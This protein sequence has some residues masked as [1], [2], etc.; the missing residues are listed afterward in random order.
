MRF[1]LI[2]LFYV[3][4]LLAVITGIFRRPLAMVPDLVVKNWDTPTFFWP[5][6]H[7][8]WLVGVEPFWNVN[9]AWL[10]ARSDPP[11]LPFM[12]GVVTC[13][14]IWGVAFFSVIA[15]S[16]FVWARTAIKEIEKPKAEAEF[17]WQI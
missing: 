17:D 15:I 6:Q 11:P 7:F 4:S 9:V 1:S 10:P 12:L 14:V 16:N 5:F 2:R 8:F 3:T 13:V